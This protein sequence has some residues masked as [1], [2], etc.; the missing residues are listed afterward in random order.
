MKIF[1]FISLK[2]KFSHIIDY[3]LKLFSLDTPIFFLF[4]NMLK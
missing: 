3:L 2:E 1:S 4:G